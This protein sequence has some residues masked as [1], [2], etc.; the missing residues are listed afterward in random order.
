MKN[1]IRFTNLYAC[2]KDSGLLRRRWLAFC[3][4]W[5]LVMAL[6]FASPKAQ[7]S[8]SMGA[9]LT[10]KCLSGN[11]YKVTLTF[12]RDCSGINAPVDPVVDI[13]SAVCGQSLSVTCYAR[14]GT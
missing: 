12:Y 1:F 7:A 4:K 8:H 14:P 6:W 11:T 3:V 10:Y 13:N 9:D 5:S 2:P